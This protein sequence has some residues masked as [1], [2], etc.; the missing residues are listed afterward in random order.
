MEPLPVNQWRRVSRLGQYP[1]ERVADPNVP[2]FTVTF[3]PV[4]EFSEE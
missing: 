4:R 1:C 2:W 3:T